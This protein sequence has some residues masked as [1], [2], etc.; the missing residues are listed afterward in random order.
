MEV[1]GQDISQYLERLKSARVLCVGDVMLD[2]FCEG[3]VA[4]VSPEA[5][6]PVLHVSREEAHLGGAG[7]VA[8]NLSALSVSTNLVSVCGDDAP[9]RELEHLL[10]S[11]N[12]VTA[13]LMKLEDR[14][15]IIKTR[16]VAGGQQLLRA[17]WE[18][19]ESISGEVEKNI[20]TQVEQQL[21]EVGA[22]ILSDYGK[23]VLSEN[24]IQAI[25]KRANNANV[26]VIVDP[27]G[28]DFSCYAGASVLTP[29]RQ[30]LA[31]ASKMSV[32]SDEEVI[33][34]CEYLIENC[35]IAGVLA[36]RSE[37]GM[38]LIYKDREP[39]HLNARAMEVFDVAGAGD[40]VIATFAAGIAAGMTMEEAAWLSNVAAGIVV[41]KVGTAVAYPDEILSSAHSGSW[42]EGEGKVVSL[43]TAVNRAQRWRQKGLKVGFTNGCFD[44]L[45]PGHISLIEQASVNC[46][47]LILGLNSDSSVKRLKG[48][49]RPIQNE[50]SRA[51]VLA[52]LAKVAMVVIFSE[53]TPIELIRSIKPDVL[54]KGADY[55]VETVVGATDVQSWGG[56]VVLANLVEGQSTTSTI[57][58]MNN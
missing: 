4:R 15:T 5:P 1:T 12:G 37:Q 58:K 24:L 25:I 10:E 51:T 47:R 35:A 41:A 2:R 54:V 38:S 11:H 30:E 43:D 21:S 48:E 53:E 9:A 26:P 3:A 19:V 57:A 52:S 7:N 42:Q 18:K 28:D 6:I 39:H 27:K 17:D 23:G 56:E 49:N 8:R 46:D 45:H 32:G 40:T 34:A 29:N 20:L 16:F 22:L 33:N 55:T 31:Q 50:V 13:N 44:L 36:T 14:P